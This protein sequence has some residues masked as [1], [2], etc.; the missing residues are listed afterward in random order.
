MLRRHHLDAG[1]ERDLGLARLRGPDRARRQPGLDRERHQ[2]GLGGIAHDAPPGVAIIGTDDLRIVAQRDHLEQA[3]EIAPYVLSDPPAE[4]LLMQRV[5]GDRWQG[6]LTVAG[7]VAVITAVLAGSTAALMAILV[8]CL[9][10]LGGPVIALY[11][12]YFT[13]GVL[14]SGSSALDVMKSVTDGVPKEVRVGF[15]ELVRMMVDADLAA[16]GR[17]LKGGAEAVAAWQR[18]STAV[19]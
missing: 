1:V 3:P 2:R 19:R 16:L 11:L 17:Q 15:Q 13:L 12:F 9:S 6:Y 5:P 4:R 8:F 10:F 18:A 7:M 14:G